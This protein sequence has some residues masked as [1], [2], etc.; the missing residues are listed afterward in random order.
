M[1][2]FRYNS[3]FRSGWANRQDFLVTLFLVTIA[4]CALPL[5]SYIAIDTRGQESEAVTLRVADD[6][7]GAARAALL[8]E[9]RAQGGRR[10][11]NNTDSNSSLTRSRKPWNQRHAADI[12]SVAHS[13]IQDTD[14]LTAGKFT[15]RRPAAYVGAPPQ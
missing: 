10:L 12:V 7:D 13:L 15:G 2:H 14:I 11:A 6:L 4:F 3:P 1:A 5:T 8:Y 9:D